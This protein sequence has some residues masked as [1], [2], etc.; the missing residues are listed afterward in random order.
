M[1]EKPSD[2]HGKK[3]D[4]ITRRRMIKLLSGAGMSAATL[5]SLSVDDVAAADSDQMTIPL[6]V[7]GKSK[8]RV[9]SDWY[10]RMV[11]ARGVHRKVRQKWMD[12]DD[13]VG[14]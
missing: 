1:V 3:L 10:D 14:V 13:V 4:K 12:H 5:R 11:H 9:S 2:I 6:D 7:E 8:V